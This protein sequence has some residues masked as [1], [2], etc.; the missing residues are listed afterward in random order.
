MNCEE[1]ET[2]NKESVIVIEQA[3]GYISESKEGTMSTASHES[4]KRSQKNHKRS[5]TETNK[6]NECTKKTRRQVQIS[7]SFNWNKSSQIKEKC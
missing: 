6:A 3:I 5:K 1:I 7:K 4:R 2:I